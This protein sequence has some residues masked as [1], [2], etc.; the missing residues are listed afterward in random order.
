[1]IIYSKFVQ[2][3][4]KSKGKI[5]FFDNDGYSYDQVVEM[6]NV[7]E[8]KIYHIHENIGLISESNLDYIIFYLFCSKLNKT[9]IPLD[10]D[11]TTDGFKK[12]LT[13]IPKSN[14]FVDK[15]NYQNF[16]N[17]N[18][19]KRLGDYKNI[20]RSN[21]KN[22]NNF[23]LC[24]T[25]GSTGNPKPIVLSQKVK[26][27]R[28]VSNIKI[29][30]LGR[31][32]RYLISTP[33]YHTLAIRIFNMFILN[34]S[35]IFIKSNINVMDLVR[36]IKTKK[37]QFTYFI[38]DQINQFLDNKINFNS[39]SSLKCLISSSSTL[40]TENKYKILN[41]FKK[42]F[43]ECYGLSEGAILTNLSLR[44]DK[45]RIDSVGKAIPGVSLKIKKTKRSKV[46]E[47]LFKSP[48]MFSGYLTKNSIKKKTHKGFFATGDLGYIKKGYLYFSGRKKNM[49]K[50]K[51]KSV[52]PEDIEGYL[53]KK[54]VV[55]EC[56]ILSITNKNLEEKMCLVYISNKFYTTDYRVKTKCIE[57]LK[58]H[59]LPRYYLKLKKLPKNKMGKI[60]RS[61]LKDIVSRE[62]K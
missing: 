16:K 37:I 46:G 22:N 33:L 7:L 27:L 60:N 5:I 39:L 3:F 38:S 57:I 56:V 55:K 53:L 20:N 29:Y 2:R 43:Y 52:Y 32:I 4:S 25:S 45:K 15:K 42:N 41:N 12:I 8:K 10:P 11:M 62:F 18:N 50:I 30:N 51:G 48:Q 14:I 23:I 49:I 58:N 17:F 44:K 26:I 13:T 36:F 35:K 19:I 1:M 31:S 59:N 9:F 61:K 54:S 24:F 28:A 47:I 40:S 34:G 6:I 21:K